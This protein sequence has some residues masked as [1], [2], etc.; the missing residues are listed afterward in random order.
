MVFVTARHELSVDGTAVAVEEQDVV[1]RS[2]PDGIA[3]RTMSARPAASPNRRASGGA[4]WRPIP[5]CCRRSARSPTTGTASTTTARTSRRS[6]ATR[7][8]SPT[9][10]AARWLIEHGAEHVTLAT[11]LLRVSELL[12]P[13]QLSPVYEGLAA[14]Q[15][16][17]RTSMHVR[18]DGDGLTHRW[19]GDELEFADFDTVV[20][21]GFRRSNVELTDVGGEPPWSLTVIG[22]AYAP[23]RMADAV[24]EGTR[25]ASN[26]EAQIR[27]QPDEIP[28]HASPRAGLV[29]IQSHCA[30]ALSAPLITA[31]TWRT[32]DAA[33]PPRPAAKVKQAAAHTVNDGLDRSVSEIDVPRRPVPCTPGR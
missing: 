17:T 19:V 20:T 24:L 18:D 5:S 26:S 11:D 16:T 28:L 31:C 21:V 33:I 8:S 2:E 32:V 10:A 1:Y 9:A 12:D 15:V 6:R 27:R 7:T 22:D 14:A 25:T 23:R 13:T 4:A 29:A 3:P 30:A